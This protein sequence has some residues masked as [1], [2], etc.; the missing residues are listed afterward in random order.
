L[1]D[2]D[3]IGSYTC[4]SVLE[5]NSSCVVNTVNGGGTAVAPNVTQ[6]QIV[7]IDGS[8][9]EST[10][11]G[12]AMQVISVGSTSYTAS[13][14]GVI[15]DTGTNASCGTTTCFDQLF[16]YSGATVNITGVTDSTFNLSGVTIAGST[17]KT[18]TAVN[19]VA[20]SNF[21]YT[22][23]VASVGASSTGGSINMTGLN[24][25]NITN[26]QL[27]S[28]S[29]AFDLVPQISCPSGSGNQ[30]VYPFVTFSG[31][32]PAPFCGNHYSGLNS[33]NFNEEGVP[34]NLTCTTP[35]SCT[36]SQLGSTDSET[37]G[38]LTLVTGTATNATINVSKNPNCIPQDILT[39]PQAD[40]KTASL[41]PEAIEQ[42]GLTVGAYTGGG[43]LST[44]ITVRTGEHNCC[45]PAQ[46]GISDGIQQALYIPTDLA[47]Q[48]TFNGVNGLLNSTG[49]FSNAAGTGN[50]TAT[51][52]W[53]GSVTSITVSSGTGIHSGQVV[54]SSLGGLAA[55]TTVANVTGTTVTLS[56]ATTGTESSTT[57]SFVF[58]VSGLDGENFFTANSNAYN[59][60]NWTFSPVCGATCV[61]TLQDVTSQ[62]GPA[63][64]GAFWG[65]YMDFMFYG[66]PGTTGNPTSW[67]SCTATLDV[68]PG[69]SVYCLKN[70][71]L[72]DSHTH[73]M[74]INQSDAA[75]GN[76]LLDG[77]AGSLTTGKAAT[78][79]V[80]DMTL[81][82][83]QTAA[84][85]APSLTLTSITGNVATFTIPCVNQSGTGSTTFGGINIMH[86]M[87][88]YLTGFNTGSLN[89][90]NQWIEIGPTSYTRSAATSC[91]AGTFT[92]TVTGISSYSGASVTGAGYEGCNTASTTPWLC[93][94]GMTVGGL[95]SPTGAATSTSMISM[96]GTYG[97]AP[98]GTWTPSSLTA[99]SNVFTVYVP[100]L[101][102]TVLDVH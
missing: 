10:T 30:Y 51:S 36:V 27:G 47:Y 69:L 7:Q 87:P 84:A 100:P 13:P 14:V 12:I 32:G 20:G 22:T 56:Q 9:V 2:L 38:L 54:T 28:N 73:V 21:T 64:Q 53:I 78:L 102:I 41:N 94:W 68:L 34:A 17:P 6:G 61:N 16:I 99:S 43:N 96:D 35:T 50:V 31:G 23:G 63:I 66:A 57:L 40:T 72:N 45:S 82:A 83:N 79:S 49:I 59:I 75:A 58:P 11:A 60:A 33:S 77:S 89:L 5:Q 37:G 95:Q 46:H 80:P 65:H 8:G 15:I 44:P 1:A 4:T 93:T 55:N 67:L 24:A 52:S 98:L 3:I 48:A 19:G 85:E 62:T 86:N 29:T 42:K 90:P 74:I 101:S 97:G 71:S 88:L 18:R 81:T 70:T 92:A 76:V 91:S 26:T 39:Y 25:V